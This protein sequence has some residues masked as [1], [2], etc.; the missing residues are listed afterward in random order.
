MG[1]TI[2][3]FLSI[4]HVVLCQIP[5]TEEDLQK[6]LESVLFYFVPT[7][8]VAT[9]SLFSIDIMSLTGQSVNWQMKDAQKRKDNE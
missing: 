9:V 6:P 7:G 2:F 3:L 4:F 5:R 1:M 8:L